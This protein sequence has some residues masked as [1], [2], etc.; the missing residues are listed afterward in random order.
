VTS[1]LRF[2]KLT[3]APKKLVSSSFNMHETVRYQ[4]VSSMCAPSAWHWHEE[5]IALILYTQILGIFMTPRELEVGQPACRLLVAHCDCQLEV[6]QHACRLLV[7]HCDC[8][9]LVD[10]I[11]GLAGGAS[12]CHRTRLAVNCVLN[13][14]LVFGSC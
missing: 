14:M 3:R 4:P 2:A 13:C 12:V 5:A 10:V 7:A 9:F 1:A 8:Q 6:G 11:V